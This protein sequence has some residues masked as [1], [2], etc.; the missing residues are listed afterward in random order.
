MNPL[1][2][3]GIRLYRV[4]V[5][6]AARR[7]NT[8]AQAMLRGHNGVFDTLRGFAAKASGHPVIW[9]H[10]SSLGE[11]EQGRPLLERIRKEH[12]DVRL[13]LTFFSP[14]GYEV[15]SG[16]TGVDCVTYLPFDTPTNAQ[17]FIDIV[18]PKAAFFVKYDF[19]GNILG[20]LS[21]RGIPTYL[22]S[23]IFRP[24]Q[25]FFHSWGG[26]FRKMLRCYTTLFVQDDRSIELLRGIGITKVVKVGDTRFDRVEGTLNTPLNLP[27]LQKWA[28]GTDPIMVAG[29]SW[30]A[31]EQIYIPWLAANPQ[32]KAVIAPHE[33]DDRRLTELT[34][35]LP[36]KA[37]LWSAV[38]RNGGIVPHDVRYLVID[39]FGV[40]SRLYRIAD[41]C[42]IGG[43]FGAGIHNIAEAAVYG[44]P[45]LFGP[46]H[47]KFREAGE[48]IA[49]GGGFSFDNGT[50][51]GKIADR[52]LADNQFRQQ[53]A[54]A[55]GSYIH[56]NLG[57]TSRVLAGV[58][59]SIFEPH[60]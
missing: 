52:L 41:L 25:P 53:A 22:V 54:D 49:C 59:S 11:F 8:K 1:Y 55:A 56:S 48:M 40:L 12:P 60:R 24:E 36:G 10:A 26:T 6:L 43:G 20:Q 2:N 23:G 31:D 33:F 15:R 47:G 32:V 57:A 5:K 51:F 37:M 27:G 18:R 13:L 34:D 58:D 38:E 14:S 28:E 44:V 42:Y 29:S 3:L 39:C 35:T 45:V 9:L 7:G 46:N 30:P 16:Y 4:G 19:W 17:L 50:A 21:R